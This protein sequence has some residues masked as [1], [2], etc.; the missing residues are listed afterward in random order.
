M[1][2]LPLTLVG[3]GSSSSCGNKMT[4]IVGEEYSGLKDP[5]F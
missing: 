1:E 2:I 5:A 4:L 3:F